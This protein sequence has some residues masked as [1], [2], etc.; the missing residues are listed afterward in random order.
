MN[1]SIA[2]PRSRSRIF[3]AC[4]IAPAASFAAGLGAGV[5]VAAGEMMSA[6]GYG[7]VCVSSAAAAIG[8]VWPRRPR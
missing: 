6:C 3:T 7:L 4:G 5:C 2:V 1:A 8:A